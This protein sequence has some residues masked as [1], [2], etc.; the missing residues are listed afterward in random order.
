MYVWPV[1]FNSSPD[2]AITYLIS[3][4]NRKPYEYKKMNPALLI[5]IFQL[6]CYK[7]QINTLCC[8]NKHSFPRPWTTTLFSNQQRQLLP[9][10]AMAENVRCSRS[11]WYL[12]SI[13]WYIM[14]TMCVFF[15][16]QPLK[17]WWPIVQHRNTERKV[18]NS[19]YVPRQHWAL[20]GSY[21]W[22]FLKGHNQ[23]RSNQ[24]SHLS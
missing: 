17:L 13:H 15:F 6:W 1:P 10:G 8:L 9:P 16:G 11:N 2:F 18:S 21:V 14:P 3:G 7:V 23:K 24:Y 12:C 19:M 5:I 20:K 4:S 22:S